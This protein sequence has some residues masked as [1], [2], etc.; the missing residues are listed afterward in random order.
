MYFDDTYNTHK[1]LKNHLDAPHNV[2]YEGKLIATDIG[3]IS[4][5]DL[6]LYKKEHISEILKELNRISEGKENFTAKDVEFDVIED[7][8]MV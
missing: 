7:E 2:C 8:E 4:P 3:F 1:V 5:D 6:E